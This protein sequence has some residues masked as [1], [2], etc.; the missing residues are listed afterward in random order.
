MGAMQTEVIQSLFT[1][2]LFLPN[3]TKEMLRTDASDFQTKV[4]EIKERY[5]LVSSS[6][7]LMK[8][9]TSYRVQYE[10][11]ARISSYV[12]SGEMEEWMKLAISRFDKFDQQK[13][14][15][16]WAYRN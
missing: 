10:A 16:F 2:F 12:I 1:G 7:K 9:L 6:E 14:D 3:I 11:K 8:Y 15:A 13:N 5:K 4:K